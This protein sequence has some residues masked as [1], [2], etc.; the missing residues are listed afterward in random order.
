MKVLLLRFIEA[1]ENHI[2][3]DCTA[4]TKEQLTERLLACERC[5]HRGIFRCRNSDCGCFIWIKARM[6]S[7][8]CPDNP[9][10]WPEIL[11]ES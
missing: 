4:V 10:R 6:R 11:D 1:I 5:P 9:P 2:K 3:D 7:Q 8:R